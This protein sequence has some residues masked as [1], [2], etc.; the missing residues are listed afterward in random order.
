MFSLLPLGN[1]LGT[2]W[3]RGLIRA[4][5][6][7]RGRNGGTNGGLAAL[8]LLLQRQWLVAHTAP[9][10]EIRRDFV[11]EHVKFLNGVVDLLP[12]LFHRFHRLGVDNLL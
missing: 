12:F 9:L 7:S 4:V 6:Q 8:L 2:E 11:G 3:S 10:T 5:K 1:R